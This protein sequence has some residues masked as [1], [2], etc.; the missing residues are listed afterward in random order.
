MHGKTTLYANFTA[1]EHANFLGAKVVAYATAFLDG[2]ND[3][4][5]LANHAR[6]M[7]CELVAAPDDP[8]GNPILDLA[9]LLVVA[10]TGAATAADDARRD[11]WM[12]V[13]GA[14]VELVRLEVKRLRETGGLRA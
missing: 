7:M 8:Q 9:R 10:M 13:M 6:S 1:A 3:A 12:D 5:M 11:R 14:L 4:A 2:R